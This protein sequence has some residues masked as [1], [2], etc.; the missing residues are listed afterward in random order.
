MP[1]GK[2]IDW[3]KIK[4]I[5]F[6]VDGTLY[7]QSKLR[8]KMLFSL[9]TYYGLRPW[10]IREMALLQ[11]FRTEREKRAGE[12][13]SDLEEE[14]YQWC[15]TKRKYPLNKIKEVV[16]KWIFQYPLKYLK[17]C[18]FP[19][20]KDL[21]ELLREKGIIIAIYSDYKAQ[22]KLNAMELKADLVVCSTD[23]E[24]NC[25]KPQPKGL[26]YISK[27]LQIGPD[28]CL[29]IG[30]RQEMDG[31]CA[32]S[33]KMPYLIIDKKPQKEFSFFHYLNSEIIST[34]N[35]T[36]YEPNFYAAQK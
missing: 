13:F 26:E 22:A 29:F 21:F 15:L 11:L 28:A 34:F 16:E 14:Q 12:I 31:E 5:I 8:K 1:T 25:L 27:K 17:E 23:P 20:T 24:I 2:N 33:A 10:K 30:D 36:S 6:D 9:L 35:S 3:K 7:D 32:I 19:G 4:V 18:M